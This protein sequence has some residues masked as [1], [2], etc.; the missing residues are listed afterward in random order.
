VNQCAADAPP[1]PAARNLR[2]ACVHE[3]AHWAVARSLGASGFVTIVREPADADGSA[4][5]GG[6]FQMHGE[7][8]DGDW[9]VVALAGTVAECYDDDKTISATTIAAAIACGDI[10]FTGTDAKLATGYDDDDVA[11]CLA[12]VKRAW[13]E[14]IADTAAIIDARD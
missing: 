12:L 3:Y 5:F 8:D 11:R 9:R 14:I 1:S 7:L 13:P 2:R 10:E 4:Q 6:R